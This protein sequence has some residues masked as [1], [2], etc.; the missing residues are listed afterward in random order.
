[1]A[2]PKGKKGA[3][4]N[5]A[6]SRKTNTITKSK[7]TGG[8]ASGTMRRTATEVRSTKSTRAADTAAGSRQIQK[9]KSAKVVT[10]LSGPTEEDIRLRAYEIY[11]R[12]GCAPGDPAADWLQAERELRENQHLHRSAK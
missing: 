2:R 12:R 8:T 3:K 9:T 4:G 6:M 10:G 5:K 7:K 11:L 1:M